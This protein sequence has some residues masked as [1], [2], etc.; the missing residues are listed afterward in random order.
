MN[1]SLL[2]LE[3]AVSAGRANKEI[4]KFRR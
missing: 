2:V 3:I 1:L 4:S